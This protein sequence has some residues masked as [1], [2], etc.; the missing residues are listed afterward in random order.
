MSPFG[1]CCSSVCFGQGYYFLALG[2]QG[3]DE[4]LADEVR[5]ACASNSL[6]K[7]APTGHHMLTSLGRQQLTPGFLEWLEIPISG[8]LSW[9][10]C[11]PQVLA[12]GARWPSV[13][14]AAARAGTGGL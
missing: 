3:W 13:A 1:H 11:A 12:G 10:I 5:L 6:D 14:S 7:E 4:C 2:T 9:V 8:T